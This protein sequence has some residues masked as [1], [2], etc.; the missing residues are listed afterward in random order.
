MGTLHALAVIAGALAV[1]AV[2][3]SALH[4]VVLPRDESVLL[5]RAVFAVA[6]RLF[7]FRAGMSRTYEARDRVM[8]RFAPV[9][10]M[11]LPAVWVAAMIGGFTLV[12]WGV[13]PHRWRAAFVLSGASL[14]TL[15]FAPPPSLPSELAAVAEAVIGLG[16]VAMLISYLPSIYSSF[17]RREL[18]V[19]MLDVRAGS[20]PSSVALLVR[21]HRIGRPE[22]ATELFGVWETWFADVEE[23][24]TSQRALAFFRSPLPGRSWIT[25]AGA[26]LDAAAL[27]LSTVDVPREP[28]P[29]L[30]I[31]AGFLALR[32]IAD[33]FDV[34]YDPDPRPT[35]QITLSRAEYD[36]ACDVLAAAGVPLVADRE[37]AW[38]DFRGW[39]VNYDVVL[40]ALAGLLMAPYAPW[41]SDRS[42]AFGRRRPVRR[43]R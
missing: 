42:A 17:E 24:H 27:S 7:Q 39:R 15:G 5:T 37:Q 12:Q 6:Q 20:P 35:D 14:T 40:V 26:V 22:S 16:L 10:L 43:R 3:L 36:E 2:G 1:V 13:G 18:A 30:C 23:T 41:S 38:R 25:A 31:R 9:A 32:R 34:D 21:H 28:E 33:L 29:Q 8:A 4:T 11:L 19:T